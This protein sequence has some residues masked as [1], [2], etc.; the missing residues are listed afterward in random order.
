MSEEIKVS[1]PYR[2]GEWLPSDRVILETWLEKHIDV[3]EKEKKPFLPVIQE[4]QNLIESD[5]EIYMLFNQMF[6]QVPHWG[7]YK[8]NPAGDPQVRDYKHMLQ[9]LN[10]IMTKAPEY[11]KTQLVGFPINAILDWS[12]GTEGGY[13]AFLNDKV[14]AMLKKVLNEWG[15]FLKSKDSAYV[16]NDDPK[17]GWLGDDAMLGMFPNNNNDPQEAKKSFITTFICQPNED[18]WGFTS[19]D[20]FFT[21]IFNEGQRPIGSPDD[22]SIIVNAC[23]SA[24]YKIATNVQSSEKFWIK[25]QPYSLQHMLNNDEWVEKFVG[26]TIYQAFLSAKSYHRWNSPVSGTIVKV[27]V[28]DGTYYSEIPAEGFYNPLHANFFDK[29]PDDSAP[30]DSQGYISEVATRAMIFIEADNPDIGL[31]CFLAIGMAEVSSCDITVYEGQHVEKG[32][33]TGMFHFGGSTHCLI[34]GPH[35]KLDFDLNGQ[36]PGLD[37]TNILVRAKLATVIK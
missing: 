1:T 24:P 21:R 9:L 26:G 15:T 36:K 10:S 7:R 32:D 18:H 33:Q 17:T 11:N 22:D 8:N 14:N 25:A 30:N 28:Q 4:F 29:N 27:Y 23:E 12:M 6:S 31:M 37:S 2:V 5:A 3:A 20:N 34:F 19:W 35:V 13:A 16:L